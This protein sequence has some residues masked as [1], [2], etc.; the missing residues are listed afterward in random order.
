MKRLALARVGGATFDYVM[1]SLESQFFFFFFFV[2]LSKEIMYLLVSL[3][4]PIFFFFKFFIIY[5]G[6]FNLLT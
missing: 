5:V 1:F 6:L 3:I 4:F 2:P